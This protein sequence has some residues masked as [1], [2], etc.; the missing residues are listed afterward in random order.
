[1]GQTSMAGIDMTGEA[2]MTTRKGNRKL[3]VYDLKLTMAWEGTAEGEPAPV[4]GTVKVEEFASG[5]DEGDYMWEVTVEGSGAAQSA[6][7]RAMEVAGT[8]QLSRLL[9]SLAKELE[10]VS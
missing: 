2:A 6:A 3:A 8:A 9:S 7:K 10:D 5:S 4:K 1:M